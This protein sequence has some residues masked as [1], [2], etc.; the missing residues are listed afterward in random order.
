MSITHR[1]YEKATR[2]CSYQ[3]RTEKE[4]RTKLRA[5]GVMQEAEVAQLIQTLK[6]EKFLDEERYVASLDR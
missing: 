6:A 3:D 4:V 1:A 2:Y 5:L